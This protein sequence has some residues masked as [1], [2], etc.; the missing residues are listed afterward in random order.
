LRVLR[1]RL[2]AVVVAI[3]ATTILVGII[4]PATT[5]ASDPSGLPRFMRAVGHIESGG[6]Y[7]ARNLM[8]GA[9]GKYQIL[10]S[11][12]AAWAR[13]YLGDVGAPATPANQEKVAHDKMS[14]LFRWLGTWRRVAY[15]WLTGS[16]R[17][18]GWSDSA[19]RYVT[20]I[21]AYYYAV[22]GALTP[23]RDKG[24]TSAKAAAKHFSERSSS[25]DY[26]GSWRSASFGR[27]AGGAVTYASK[28]GA[29]ASFSFT[30][31]RIVWYG[32]VGPTRGKARVLVDGKLVKTVNLQRGSFSSRKAI[33]TTH[34]SSAGRHTLRIEVVA[35]PGRK[36]VAIDELVVTK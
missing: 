21:M 20:R 17:T 23:V 8:S 29:T 16:D 28:A 34:W 33:F 7:S 11:S 13:Q 4:G 27:Y 15:W 30:G 14:G 19:T 6:N 26:N 10:P 3:F 2:K 22:G 35:T 36:L 18:T 25:I 12:W 5:L 1:G 32:P 24:S 31:R 9:Y